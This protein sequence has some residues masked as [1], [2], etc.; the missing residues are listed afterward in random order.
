M[1]AAVLALALVGAGC[2]QDAPFPDDDDEVADDAGTPPDEGIELHGRV[3]D[4]ETCPI[5]PGCAAV[6][7][8][9]V[10]VHGSSASSAP[11]GREGAFVVEDAPAGRELWLAVRGNAAIARTLS[12][13]PIPASDRDVFDIVLYVLPRGAGTLLDGI[14]RES[15]IDLEASGGYVGQAVARIDPG[16]G[17]DPLCPDLE[18]GLCAIEGVAAAVR[19]VD[20]GTV[21]YVNALP[22]FVPEGPVLLP[23]AQAT[24]A[25][26][27]F[28][29]VPARPESVALDIEPTHASLVVPA[30]LGAPVEPGAVTLGFHRAD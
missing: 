16:E 14:Q 7:G 17:E 29:V 21:T 1:R 25:T 6:E 12:G 23:L 18:E 20:Y 2:P 15:G 5:P 9:V 8:M 26:G 30:A 4:F 19:P 28:L 10:E 13:T 11:T 27:I 3:V 24:T 22:S